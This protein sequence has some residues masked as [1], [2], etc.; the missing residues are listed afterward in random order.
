VIPRFDPD[1]NLPAG[2]HRATWPEIVDR[3]GTT[4]WRLRLVG[5]LL[6]ALKAL[7]LAGCA[8]VYLN[9]SF[10]TAKESPGDFDACWEITGVDPDLLDPVLLVF[11]DGRAAQKARFLGELFPAEGEADAVGT[12][13]LDYFQLDRRTG[14]RKGIIAI[15]LG[16]LP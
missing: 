1:G 6:D 7:H 16:E 8:R 11:D 9:G 3:L 10:V 15:D 13:Y 2:V 14:N 12:I 5:G 4:A